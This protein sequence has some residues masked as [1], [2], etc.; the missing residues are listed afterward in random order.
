MIKL[1]T[2][3]VISVMGEHAGENEVQIFERKINDIE[4]IGRTFWL[5]R[6]H[7]AKPSMVQ[8]LIR[9]AEDRKENVSLVFIE[10]SSVGGAVPTT[11][12]A[13]AREYSRDGINWEELPQN[14]SLVTGKIDKGAYALVFQNLVFVRDAIDLWNYADFLNQ[15]QPIRIFQGASTFCAIKRDMSNHPTKIKSHYRKAI[16]VGVMCEPYCVWLR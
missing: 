4:R 9:E 6:S 12:A 1:G 15:E 11:T 7:Q 8:S 5:I 2:Y 16:A 13:Y 14:L 3:S 10:P